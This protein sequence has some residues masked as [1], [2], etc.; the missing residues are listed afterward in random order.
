M[1]SR[2]YH[3]LTILRG[4]ILFYKITLDHMKGNIRYW[5]SRI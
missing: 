2:K 5:N 1:K 3:R 4:N